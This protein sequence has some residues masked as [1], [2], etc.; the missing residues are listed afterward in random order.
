MN[1]WPLVSSQYLHLTPFVVTLME[2]GGC[3][4]DPCRTNG[5]IRYVATR[6]GIRTFPIACF[7]TETSGEMV[8]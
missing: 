7:G 4:L 1:L 5:E 3:A 6:I 2:A 8:G